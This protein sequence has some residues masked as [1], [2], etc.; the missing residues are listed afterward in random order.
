[1]ESIK[2]KKGDFVK[3]IY[4]TIEEV[5]RVNGIMVVTYESSIGNG[6]WHHTKVWKIN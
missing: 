5:M 4:G 2:L 1:M 3:T 6:G